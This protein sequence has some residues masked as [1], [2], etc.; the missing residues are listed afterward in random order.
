[1]ARSCLCHKA[2]CPETSGRGSCGGG[3]GSAVL[4]SEVRNV[5]YWGWEAEM[6]SPPETP[7]AVLKPWGSSEQ[8]CKQPSVCFQPKPRAQN[9]EARPDSQIVA[10]GGP[11]PH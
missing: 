5:N 8:P 7:S 4:Y 1:M 11:W 9:P 6:M 10:L 3:G 2:L